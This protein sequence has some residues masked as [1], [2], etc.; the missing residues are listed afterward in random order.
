MNA[1]EVRSRE[2]GGG[3]GDQ[4][5]VRDVGLVLPSLSAT[6]LP[7]SP[8]CPGHWT[9]LESRPWVEINVTEQRDFTT[10]LDLK[11]QP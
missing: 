8:C 3:V 4:E 9:R 6:C 7:Q 10:G 5:L 11:N 1:R 2:L